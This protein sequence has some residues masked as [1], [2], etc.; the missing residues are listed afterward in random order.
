[1]KKI[2]MQPTMTVVEIMS[3]TG[4]LAGS[5]KSYGLGAN[6][7]NESDEPGNATDEGV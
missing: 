7:L 6:P 4:L 5:V 2:Y 3:Q 1:M